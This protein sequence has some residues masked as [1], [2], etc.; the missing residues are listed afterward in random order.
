MLYEIYNTNICSYGL[1]R[2][3]KYKPL[4]SNLLKVKNERLLA[5]CTGISSGITEGFMITPAELIKV[6]FVRN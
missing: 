6:R 4:Y 1:Q 5:M 3:L 2:I